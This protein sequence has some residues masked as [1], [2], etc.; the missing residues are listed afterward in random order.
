MLQEVTELRV[1]ATTGETETVLV[2]VD[3]PNPRIAEI[4]ERLMYL[5]AEMQR[6]TS[7]AAD[8]LFGIL[9]KADFEA[10]SATQQAL[11]VE[12]TELEKEQ[13]SLLAQ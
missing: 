6:N 7:F 11:A 3:L 2:M 13:A 10:I 8:Y 5:N 1:N 9:P 4:S 12:R